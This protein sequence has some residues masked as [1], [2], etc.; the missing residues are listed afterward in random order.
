MRN[1]VIGTVA[2]ALSLPILAQSDGSYSRPLH[3]QRIVHDPITG[4]S[5]T[6]DEYYVGNQ[7]VAVRGGR[8]VIVDR[9][10][11]TVTE[12]DRGRSSWSESGLSTPLMAR[13]GTA[14]AA[15][16]RIREQRIGGDGTLT[17]QFENHEVS[18][19]RL[20][21][22]RGIRLS[23]DAVAAIVGGTSPSSYVSGLVVDA[24][25]DGEGQAFLP[26]RIERTFDVGGEELV[27]VEELRFV[28][29]EAPPAEL[30]RLPEGAKRE[31]SRA[32][33]VGQALADLEEPRR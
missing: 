15:T 3:V 1:L 16:P 20:N 11:G 27:L 6:I 23:S 24:T 33:R 25:K 21:L 22:D 26:S 31:V 4:S 12:I 13:Q 5:S 10:K 14:G 18:S 9:Q 7:I 17:L 28:A 32:D 30:L 19:I 8:V 29:W 2:L